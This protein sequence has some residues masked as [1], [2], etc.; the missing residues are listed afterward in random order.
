MNNRTNFALRNI[1]LFCYIYYKFL[2][3]NVIL[4]DILLLNLLDRNKTN[5]IFKN[6]SSLT[7]LD[8]Y[9]IFSIHL[10]H[11]GPMED[12]TSNYHNQLKIDLAK[13]NLHVVDN[14][15]INIS[16]N[17]K[18]TEEQNVKD[19]IASSSSVKSQQATHQFMHLF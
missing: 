8:F 9:K 6:R 19:K 3:V 2:K 1:Y 4:I 12:L 14:I 16:P 17:M 5:V 11:E 15:S 13:K 7:K 10:P 18:I